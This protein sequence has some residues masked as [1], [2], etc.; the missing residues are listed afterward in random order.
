MKTQH[1]LNCLT[2][3]LIMSTMATA[4]AQRRS[5]RAKHLLEVDYDSIP[6]CFEGIPIPENELAPEYW[7]QM[8]L[9]FPLFVRC[10]DQNINLRLKGLVHEADKDFVMECLNLCFLDPEDEQRPN[11]LLQK[12]SNEAHHVVQAVSTRVLPKVLSHP[13]ES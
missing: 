13:T 11:P 2:L 12:L 8:G 6:S 3:L 7:C 9:S 5:L 4:F 10:M 1:K